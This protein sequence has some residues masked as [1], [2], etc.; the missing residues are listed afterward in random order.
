MPRARLIVPAIAAVVTTAC[1]LTAFAGFPPGPVQF[2][3]IIAGG[4][5][6]AG[7]IGPT[8]AVVIDVI[9]PGLRATG[10]SVLSV[11]RNLFGLAGGPLLTGALSDAYGLQ[12]AMTVVPLFGLLA[13]ALYMVA[14]RT[15]LSDLKSVE[16][17]VPTV[18]IELK[19][20]VA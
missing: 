6:M 8:D 20:Q 14:A 4:I 2:G 10:A 5:V 15:Y 1:M 12:F 16:R 17:A 11:T 13:A 18:E 7:S 19:P 3:L 9:H